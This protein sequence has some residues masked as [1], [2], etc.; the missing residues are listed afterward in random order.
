MKATWYEVGKT[1]NRS[2]ARAPPTMENCPELDVRVIAI[3]RLVK[4]VLKFLFFFGA[5][6]LMIL[7]GA[8]DD[9]DTCFILQD[10]GHFLCI[11]VRAA[12]F[13]IHQT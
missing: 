3:K 1:V 10:F 13:S 7:M 5:A 12:W 4:I 11:S 2:H 6:R 9:F 8:K